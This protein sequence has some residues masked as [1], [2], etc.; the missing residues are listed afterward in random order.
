MSEKLTLGVVGDVTAFHREPESGYAFVGSYLQELDIVF[1]QNERLYTTSEDIIPAVGWTEVTRPENV[2]GLKLGNYDVI[3][4]ASN[5]SGD[6]GPDI[7]MET[8]AALRDNGFAVI[9]AG[10]NIAEARKPAFVDRGDTR[11]GFLG[12]CSLLRPNYEAGPQRPG[13]VPMRAHTHY[14]QVDYQPGT[15]PKIL[16]F[17]VAEDLAAMVADIRAAKEQCDVLAVSFHWGV[18][19]VKGVLPDYEHAVARAA[20]DAGADVIIGHGP[21]VIKAIEF[22]N[23][24]PIFHSLGNFCFDLPSKLI[25]EARARNKEFDELIA[26]HQEIHEPTEYDEWYHPY[27]VSPDQVLSLIGQVEIVDKR[28]G[29]VSFRPV[30]INKRAQPVVQKPDDPGFTQVLDYL[31]EVTQSEGIS[32]SYTI[33]GD[34]VVCR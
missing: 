3:S 33:E 26:S 23:G 32:T 8:I 24:K 6:L 21:H 19:L 17:P 16:T 30:V 18:H 14:Q 22:Y 1:A 27:S 10:A 25:E 13:A 15:K 28:V 4:C 9:G 31:T 12:Y 7:L 2:A 20:I 29:R 34:E 11:V 5:H